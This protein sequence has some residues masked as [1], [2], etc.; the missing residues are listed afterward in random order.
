MTHEMAFE[1]LNHLHQD[2]INRGERARLAEFV[3]ALRDR[4]PDVYKE[5]A[6]FYLSWLLKDALAEGRLDD[7]PPLA[8]E[9]ATRAGRDIDT[10]NRSLNALAYH[11]QLAVLVEALRIAWPDVRSSSNIVPWGIPEFA[12]K[13][14]NYEIYDYIEHTK[15]PDPADPALLERVKFFVKEPDLDRDYLTQFI[16]DL[17]G[18]VAAAWTVDDFALKPP[19]K[20]SRDDWD[21][22]EER[23]GPPDPGARNLSRL[24][25]Q[26]VGYL[27]REEGV[28]FPRGELVRQELYRYFVRR[29]KGELDP[30]P[31]MLEQAIHPKKKLPPPPR[32]GHPLCPERVTLEVCLAGLIGFL[33]GLYHT[34]AALFEVIPAWLRF[35]ES[36]KLID[37][38]RRDK[39]VA[40]L[41][42]L[43]ASLLRLLETY[44]DD[45]TMYRAV[46]AWPA[47]A[48]KGLP[49]PR[50]KEGGLSLALAA[51]ALQ[52]RESSQAEQG[53]TS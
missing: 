11:G 52:N 26:F 3:G 46:Q 8:R 24:I 36:R 13:G 23:G 31:S 30:R 44:T 29:H 20:K 49:E 21:E 14:A 53:P 38:D 40:E 22:G 43:Q 9:I 7:V 1:M 42:P 6:H 50:E 32:P 35:L 45:P 25:N 17:T 37:A 2:L 18:Q 39:T 28:P 33:S 27:R 51:A 34:L 5:G 41:R 16:T 48:V 19:R 4:L 47:V 10:V 15:S 12:N